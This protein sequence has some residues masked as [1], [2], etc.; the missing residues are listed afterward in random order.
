MEKENLETLK[1]TRGAFV[2]LVDK[3]TT[4]LSTT[5]MSFARDIVVEEPSR[6]SGP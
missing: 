5:N 2:V 6:L 1:A 4:Q 3:L